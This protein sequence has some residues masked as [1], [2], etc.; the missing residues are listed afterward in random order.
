M[1]A[2]ERAARPRGVRGQ[3]AALEEHL[4]TAPAAVLDVGGGP[5]RYAIEL[6]GRGYD[7]TFEDRG[8]HELRG[9]A[10]PQRVF[11]ARAKAQ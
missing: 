5:G 8:E 7:V 4:P 6:A 1:G 3:H 11:A 2:A 9:I 10:E